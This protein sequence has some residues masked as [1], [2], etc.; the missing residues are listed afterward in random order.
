MIKKIISLTLLIL[1]SCSRHCMMTMDCYCQISTGMSENELIEKVGEPYSR[2]R[3]PN[4]SVEYKYIERLNLGQL[5]V[6]E[7]CYYIILSKDRVVNKRY[8]VE[9]PPN[10]M[11]DSYFYQTARSDKE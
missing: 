10:Y 3:K 8:S 4:G 7:R 11:K 5:T 6:Q 1:S 2:C 9:T